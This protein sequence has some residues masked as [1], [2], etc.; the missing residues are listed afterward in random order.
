M[1]LF[2]NITAL[3]AF[4]GNKKTAVESNEIFPLNIFL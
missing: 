4:N 2:N 1:A 3:H